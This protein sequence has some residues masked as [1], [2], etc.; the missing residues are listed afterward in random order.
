MRQDAPAREELRGHRADDGAAGWIPLADDGV[1]QRY[2]GLGQAVPAG[3]LAHLDGRPVLQLREQQHDGAGL[4]VDLVVPL[5]L[6]VLV[7]G[8]LVL[9]QD[10]RSERLHVHLAEI[11]DR[12]ADVHDRKPT[13]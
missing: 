6:D 9:R 7:P 8:G 4:L 13:L 11:A 2:G 3:L 10:R 12:N 1:H 5:A